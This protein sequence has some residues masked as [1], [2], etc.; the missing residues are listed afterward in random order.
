[1]S[2]LPPAVMIQGTCSN[3]GKSLL[4]AAL[5]RI[6]TRYG[7]RVA[8]F[9]A[10]NMAL[11]SYV[12]ANGEEIGRAQA[13]QAAAA[14][15]DPDVR[16]NPVL[17]KPDSDTGSQV[18]VLGKPVGRMHAVEYFRYK[19]RAWRYVA[20]AYASLAE[21]ADV[22]VIEGAGSPAEIN[23]RKWDIVNMR[24]ARHAGAK[25]LLAADI[26]RG[27]AFAAL[28]GT[29]ALMT[30]S[31]RSM[32]SGLVLNKF[33]GDASLLEPALSVVSRRTRKPFA[34]V[35]PWVDNL[36]LPDEDS[37]SFRETGN[38]VST[39]GKTLDVALID[40]PHISNFTDTDALRCE[41]DV[42]LRKVSA[43]E[44]LGEPHLIILPGTKNTIADL[45]RL[46]ETLLAERIRTL[47]E[48]GK[49]A[50]LGICGGLQ[51]IGGII[52]DPLGT[53]S[54]GEE[55]GLNLLPLETVLGAGKQLRLRDAVWY[56]GQK[57]K[58]YEIH[59]GET[60]SLEGDKCMTAVVDGGDVLGWRRA[61]IAV[62]A[63]YLH[64]VLDADAFRRSLLDSV[65]RMHGMPA[66]ENITPY[67]VEPSLER[68]ADVVEHALDMSFVGRMLG[69]S[70]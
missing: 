18:I 40:L 49:S 43:A 62:W 14:R 69:I 20:E 41:P 25:V 27:G 65:R 50:V 45:R 5:C 17:L 53:E 29:L 8:P 26:D 61:D 31:E 59:H 42:C 23:L 13:L 10:Q 51:M 38:P 36:N 12:T 21:T 11:N 39:H 47:A 22:M 19:R 57:V 68:L 35:V 34:G 58:G 24:M 46:K 7:L 48:T 67:S 2:I 66:I 6:F 33:R 28:V 55:S 4:A 15:R 1:M 9:K 32:V 70:V 52:R 64:G 60:R 30:K 3:A 37:V 63:T 54:G 56:T 16:M 44:E